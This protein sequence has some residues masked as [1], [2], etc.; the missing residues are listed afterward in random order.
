MQGCGID[1]DNAVLVRQL[2]KLR[3]TL[4]VVRILVHAMQQ[5]DDGIVMLGVIPFWQ[6]HQKIA[7]H[8]VYRDLFLR[9]LRPQRVSTYHPGQTHCG[10]SRTHSLQLSNPHYLFSM[11]ATRG[12]QAT[13]YLV[14]SIV[15]TES[16]PH[17]GGTFTKSLR[18]SYQIANLAKAGAQKRKRRRNIMDGLTGFAAVVMALGIPI[19]IVCMY[20]FYR[21]RKLRT[22]ERLAAMQRGVEIP[23]QADLSESARSR[24]AGILLVA[25]SVGYMLAFTIV[26]R[27][28]PDAQMAAAFG[29]IPFTLGLGYFLDSTLIRRDSRTS[30]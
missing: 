13:G 16:W 15:R 24:R 20:T 21:V 17:C 7:V 18:I 11:E 30:S 1:R 2:V 27:I 25:G 26:A 3:E 8:I 5:Y 12:C 29:A 6:P 19:S 10:G 14:G 23:M 9:L 22:E 28:E 4:N